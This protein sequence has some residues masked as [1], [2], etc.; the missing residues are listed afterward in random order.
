MSLISKFVLFVTISLNCMNSTAKDSLMKNRAMKN[1]LT[2]V[3]VFGLAAGMTHEAHA[4]DFGIGGSEFT[5]DFVEIGNPGNGAD[6][7]GYGAVSYDYRMGTYE[8]SQS[9]ID[10]ASFSGAYGMPTGDWTG[11]QPSTLITWVQAAAFVNW[12]NTSTGHQA[13]YNLTWNGANWTM[14]LWDSADAWQLDGENLY[15]NKNAYYFL[16]SEDEWYKAAYH[17]DDGST[18]NYWKYP[19]ASDTVPTGIDETGDPGFDAVFKDDYNQGNPN[20]ID[21]VGIASSYGTYGQGGNV[22]EWTESA[23]DG[24]NDSTSEYRAYRGGGWSSTGDKLLSSNRGGIDP[25]YTGTSYG[26]RVASIPEPSTWVLILV[27][28]GTLLLGRRLKRLTTSKTNKKTPIL[29]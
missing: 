2:A 19:T 7:T 1:A 26:F 11:N 16:P 25:T 14:A 27:A 8:I 22:W 23:L 10:K 12:L 3:L 29:R 13:A 17:K 5:I 15:R 6:S 24:T 9:M 20:D 21:N 4:D 28:G 18:T